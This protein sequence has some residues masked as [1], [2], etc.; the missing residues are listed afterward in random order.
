MQ[1]QWKA[2]RNSYAIYQ[3]VS[4]PMILKDHLTHIS[5][6]DVFVVFVVSFHLSAYSILGL[7]ITSRSAVVE[8]ARRFMSLNIL[9]SH[10]CSLKVIRNDTV[11]ITIPLKLCLYSEIFSVKEWRD[12]ENRGRSISR[13]LKM[14]PFDRSYTNFCWSAMAQDGGQVSHVQ[15]CSVYL[16][17]FNRL[18]LFH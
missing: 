9:L 13:S 14:A 16:L 18:L 2:N 6:F 15:I 12:L 17:T 5:I 7:V 11:T 1:L 3:M 10:S 8:S 4:F